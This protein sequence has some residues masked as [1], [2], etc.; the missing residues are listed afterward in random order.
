MYRSTFGRGWKD[1]VLLPQQKKSYGVKVDFSRFTDNCT[2]ITN[3][4][5]SS[6][7]MFCKGT[8]I[9]SIQKVSNEKKGNFSPSKFLL[10]TENAQS[11]TASFSHYFL[12]F[13]PFN[14][15]PAV[16]SRSPS[17]WHHLKLSHECKNF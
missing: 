10:I 9:Y 13:L 3:A 16:Q 4:K 14:C 5:I 6:N 8:K 11:Q 17:T 15:D 1:T 12:F 2:K 7:Y